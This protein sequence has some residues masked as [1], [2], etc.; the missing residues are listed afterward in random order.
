MCE[1]AKSLKRTHN[2]K[3]KKM[4][5]TSRIIA[6][7]YGINGNPVGTN[8]GVYNSFPNTSAYF[9]P[10]PASTT[11][12]GVTC[13]SIIVLLPTGL[14]VNA[15]KFYSDATTAQLVTNGS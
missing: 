5:L 6:S 7:I 2:L 1:T 14:N 3:L 9:Y 12:N 10:A 11:F 8:N 15:T 4:A 13:N